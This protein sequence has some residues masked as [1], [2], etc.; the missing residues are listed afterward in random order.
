MITLL[1]IEFHYYLS[2]YTFW[3]SDSRII[4]FSIRSL[5]GLILFVDYTY[6]FIEKLKLILDRAKFSLLFAVRWIVS[7]YHINQTT[8]KCSIDYLVYSIRN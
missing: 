2:K 4:Y 6:R 5:T 1:K 8:G 7:F 3:Y